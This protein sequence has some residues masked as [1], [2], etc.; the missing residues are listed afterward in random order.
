MKLLLISITTLAIGSMLYLLEDAHPLLTT[1]CNYLPDGLWA[2]SLTALICFLWQDDSNMKTGWCIAGV[3][4]MIG[5][6]IAQHFQYVGGTG[7]ILDCLVYLTASLMVIKLDKTLNHI[8]N[9]ETTLITTPR[10][11]ELQR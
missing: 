2:A 11:C 9:E 6:E 1:V 7:D 5:F 4:S 10:S 3:L 8:N